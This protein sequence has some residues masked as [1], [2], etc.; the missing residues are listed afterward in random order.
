MAAVDRLY[1]TLHDCR[2]LLILNSET[3]A[4]RQNM[5]GFEVIMIAS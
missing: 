4:D 5:A 2:F 3:K 1:G